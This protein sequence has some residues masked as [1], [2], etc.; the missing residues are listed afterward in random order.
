MNIETLANKKKMISF[1]NCFVNKGTLRRTI[2]IM[3]IKNNTNK[4]N[5]LG[6]IN[7]II[8]RIKT[9]NI[10]VIGWNFTKI[11]FEGI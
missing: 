7:A 11:E 1:L 8:L 5:T 4:S 6:R 2:K 9:I 3:S 10:F